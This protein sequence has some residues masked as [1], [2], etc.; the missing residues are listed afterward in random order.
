VRAPGSSKA[1]T[2]ELI[3]AIVDSL[4]PWT[5]EREQVLA[6]V[7]EQTS[8]LRTVVQ[9]HFTREAIRE[10]RK[11]ARGLIKT[12]TQ[13]DRQFTR[14]IKRSP[15]LRS[16]LGLSDLPSYLAD[17]YWVRGICKQADK[18]AGKEDRCKRICV[19]FAKTWIAVYSKDKATINRIADIASLLYEAVT[20]K[21]AET[22]FRWL[23]RPESAVRK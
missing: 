4:K 11:G 1:T 5:V 13:L 18:A 9:E 10:T 15:E 21:K 6:A 20:G 12:I 8:L 2:D 22:S 23:Q 3:N 14:I 16:R 17:L 19:D 7:R